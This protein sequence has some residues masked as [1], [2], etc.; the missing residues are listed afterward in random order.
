MRLALVTAA[1]LVSMPTLALAMEP[2]AAMHP[3][4][5]K[6]TAGPPMLPPGGEAAVLVGD[7]TKEGP[8]VT[9]FR[10]KAGYK[11]PP[12]THPTYESLTVL[13]GSIH[14]GMGETFDMTKGQKVQ[15]GGFLHLP[16][17]MTHYVWF[18]EPGTI[19]VNSVGPFEIKYVNPADDP[20]NAT[21][22]KK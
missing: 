10:A 14:V 16:R 17:G 20:R 11:I 15:A 21:A 3:N 12:H 8:L 6:W 1:L 18:S 2:H 19:Q 9:R 5:I 22:Q 7:P 4:A 13:S